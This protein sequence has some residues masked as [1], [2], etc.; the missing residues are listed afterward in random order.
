VQA[1]AIHEGTCSVNA[2]QPPSEVG[3]L[4]PECVEEGTMEKYAGI[5]TQ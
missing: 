1:G 3:D 2:G 4:I 5:L